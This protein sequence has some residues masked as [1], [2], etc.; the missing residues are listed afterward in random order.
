MAKSRADPTNSPRAYKGIEIVNIPLP[1]CLKSKMEFR[2]KSGSNPRVLI[3]G[4]ASYLRL[5]EIWC[6][7]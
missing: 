4:F 5:K 3:Q 7:A 2:L 1:T 6:L